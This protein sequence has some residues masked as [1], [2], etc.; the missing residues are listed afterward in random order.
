ME[1][2]ELPL[3][4]LGTVVF[5]GG[6]LPL[7]IF[8]PRYLDMVSR[9]L[10]TSSGFGVVAIRSG[11]ETGSA[12]TFSV[13]TTVEITNW[14]QDDAGLLAIMT[15][16]RARFRVESQERRP[17]GLY[18]GRVSTLAAE[19]SVPLPEEQRALAAFLERTLQEVASRYRGIETRFGDAGWVGHRLVEILPLDLP[20]KQ[21]MLEM[22]DPLE[23]LDRI[24]PILE[25]LKRSR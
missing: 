4:P 22:D 14:Y 18:V 15:I 17:D 24:G 6:P 19:P 5:P 8:E 13:G 1:P 11:S 21:A 7:R 25:R 3:F 9:C 16:G 2:I 10:K 20:V 12:K 23:R